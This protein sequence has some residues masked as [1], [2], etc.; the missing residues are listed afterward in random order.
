ML[1][2]S[3]YKVKGGERTMAEIVNSRLTLELNGGA[4]DNGNSIIKYK[5]FHNVKTDATDE[6]LQTAA[7]NLGGLQELPIVSV[8][9]VNEYDISTF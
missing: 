3:I 4:D 8:K 2:L 6:D 9:R 7:I 1:F 5:S